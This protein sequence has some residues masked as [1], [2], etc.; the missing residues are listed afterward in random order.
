[1]FVNSQ[2][3]K[4]LPE[5]SLV[6]PPLVTTNFGNYY[7][8][9]AILS[10]YLKAHGFYTKQTDL[11]EDFALFLLQPERLEEMAKGVFELDEVLKEDALPCVAA[12]LLIKNR[13]KLFDDLGRHQFQEKALAPTHLLKSIAEVYQ[14]D[15][16]FSELER[17]DFYNTPVASFYEKFY[18]WSGYVENL[19]QHIHTIGISVPLGLQLIPALILARHIKS[20]LPDITLVFGGPTLSLMSKYKL[21]QLLRCTT[22]VDAVIRFEGEVALLSV[23]EQCRNST[24]EPTTIPN[25]SFFTENSVRHN[26]PISGPKLNLLPYGDYDKELL[27]RLSEPEIG[28]I[29]ARGCYWG[30]CAYCDYVQLYEGSP[31]YRTSTVNRFIEEMKYQIKLHGH[32]RFAIITE[33]IPPP[34]CLQN[35]QSDY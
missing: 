16:D 34:I 8:S 13:D 17:P 21:D 6:F 11:N 4:L 24:W 20:R 12:R 9:T 2:E 33:S 18:E 5:V 22:Q 7:P 26:D 31:S 19:S 32:N 3:E 15:L 10:G 27:A 28:I 25:L 14:T 29:Q 1:M 35:E 23:V 30:K